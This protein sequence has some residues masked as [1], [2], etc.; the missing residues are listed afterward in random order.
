MNDD[1]DDEKPARSYRT[2]VVCDQLTRYSGEVISDELLDVLDVITEINDDLWHDRDTALILEG[3]E[4][5]KGLLNILAA[6]QAPLPSL[7]RRERRR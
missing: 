5:A 1:R 7:P 3:I 4:K 2:E 6:T